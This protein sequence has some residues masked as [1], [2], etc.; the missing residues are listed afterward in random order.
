[1]GKLSQADRVRETLDRIVVE[2][3]SGRVPGAI[4]KAVYPP[5]NI[6]MAQWSLSNRVITMFNG[7]TDARGFRQWK[8]AGRHVKKGSRSFR[9]LAPRIAKVETETDDGEKSEESRC[10]GF[11]AVPVFDISQ[12]EG[13]PVDYGIPP[14]PSHPLM[15]VARAWGI[16]VRTAGCTGSAYGWHRGGPGRGPE[17]IV[18]C[19]DDEMTFFHEMT[20]AADGR[21]ESLK[22]GQDPVQESVAQLGA[23]V[24]ARLVGRKAPDTGFSF[25]YV[26]GYSRKLYP[27]LDGADALRRTCHRVLSRTCKAIE[28][29]LAA[30]D[31]GQIPAA[32]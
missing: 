5:P 3:E 20:H 6:P 23:E 15:D 19:T 25:A 27:K 24:L 17:E 22:G 13:D 11:L 18:L 9:I 8:A 31:V 14:V 1:M 10:I 21:G 30:A 32:A 26:Q 28:R 7:A 4:E 2:F 12:T 29:I 16:T